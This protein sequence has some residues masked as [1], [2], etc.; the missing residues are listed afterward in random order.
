MCSSSTNEY[1]A[2]LRT[3]DGMD[4][5]PSFLLGQLFAI[6][7]KKKCSNDVAAPPKT[8]SIKGCVSISV[9]CEQVGIVLFDQF[10][11]C[12]KAGV[13]TTSSEMQCG[14]LVD[15][16]AGFQANTRVQKYVLIH[17]VDRSTPP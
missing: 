12:C 6:N 2:A 9:Y 5:T 16:M 1:S 3:E 8:S 17:Y 4:S 13:G 14:D 15:L 7:S 11:H 10:A